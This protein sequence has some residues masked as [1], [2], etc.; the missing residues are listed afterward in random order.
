MRIEGLF[1]FVD[2][3]RAGWVGWLVCSKHSRLPAGG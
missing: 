3:S 2:D 1:G